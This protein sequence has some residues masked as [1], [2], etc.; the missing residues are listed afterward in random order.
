MTIRDLRTAPGRDSASLRADAASLQDC[1]ARLATL[2]ADLPAQQLP[3]WTDEV[4]SALAQRCLVAAADLEAAAVLFDDAPAP[5][6]GLEWLDGLDAPA[7]PHAESAFP[8]LD[9]ARRLFTLP[10]PPTA[11][12]VIGRV[13]HALPPRDETFAAA[14]SRIRWVPVRTPAGPATALP[15]DHADA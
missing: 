9:L 5:L 6:D 2:T 3:E 10:K 1:A 14:I 12:A 8:G 11:G 7:Q 13:M 15:D 4:L